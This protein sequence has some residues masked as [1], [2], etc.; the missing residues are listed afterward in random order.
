MEG[1]ATGAKGLRR[2]RAAFGICCIWL[3]FGTSAAIAQTP[4][5]R[6]WEII[7]TGQ[8]ERRTSERAAAVRALGLL[9]GDP[10][11]VEFAEKALTDK[12][13]SV[14]VAAAVALGQ[15]GSRTSIPL[16]KDALADKES[17]VFFAAA[18][19]LLS[20]GDPAGYDLYYEVL[21]GERKT[22]EN[23]TTKYKK[24]LQNPTQMTYFGLG[25]AV[26]FVPY[27]GY[28]W[29]ILQVVTKDFVS[30]V[31]AEALKRLA[32]DP[33]PRIG[34]ALA[35]AA[36]DKSW[37]VRVAALEAIARHRDP[38]LIGAV[39]PRMDDKKAAVRFTAAA[40]VLRLSSLVPDDCTLQDAA[41]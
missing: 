39:T 34:E 16:L 17:S 12:K 7:Q 33:D 5:E 13:P 30:P 36:S 10:R 14:R 26:G 4:E 20:L 21:T 35:K 9:Q 2:A 41:R 3:I 32:T 18:N 15:M 38:N 8:H 22:G 40:A 29:M 24:M 6:A 25:V 28:P 19:S 11:A 1:K 27:A 31:R 23:C 37:T